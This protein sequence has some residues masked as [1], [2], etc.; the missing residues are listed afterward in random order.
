MSESG[1]LRRCN[2]ASKSIKGRR[3][4]K[5]DKMMRRGERSFV[6]KA[7]PLEMEAATDRWLARADMAGDRA[8]RNDSH[9]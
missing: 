7:A 1:H 5:A 4:P 6:P 8:R 2:P 3:C 9:Q